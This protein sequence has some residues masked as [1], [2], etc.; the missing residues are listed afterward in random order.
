MRSGPTGFNPCFN[1]SVERGFEDDPRDHAPIEVSILVL[2][3]V[4]REAG[5]DL[6]PKKTRRG[7]SILVLMEVLREE[8]VMVT[9]SLTITP[10]QSL[11]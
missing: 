11:F 5:I 10:F 3:E 7:V 2:M 6:A 9:R 8:F 1:G 4:L